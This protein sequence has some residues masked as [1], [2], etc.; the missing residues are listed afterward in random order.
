M[1]AAVAA[2]GVQHGIVTAHYAT[3][4]VFAMGT[5]VC[6]S[7][8]FLLIRIARCCEGWSIA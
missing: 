8:A 7:A 5:S 2:V 3:A 6:I 1:V 4:G